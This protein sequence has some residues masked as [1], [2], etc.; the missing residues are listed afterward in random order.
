M[1]C[2]R[3]LC[4]FCPVLLLLVVCF[5]WILCIFIRNCAR[6]N[7]RARP[8]NGICFRIAYLYAYLAPELIF[9]YVKRKRVR[10]KKRDTQRKRER[11]RQREEKKATRKRRRKKKIQCVGNSKTHSKISVH[12]NENMT[13]GARSSALIPFAL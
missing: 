4:A 12:T 9:K 7:H 8:L 1:Y 2:F 11:G 10:E 13:V 3:G 5:E 6:L